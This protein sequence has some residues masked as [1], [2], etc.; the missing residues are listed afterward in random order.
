M[1]EISK[2]WV[3]ALSLET[4]SESMPTRDNFSPRLFVIFVQKK[5]RYQ[6]REMQATDANFTTQP[7]QNHSITK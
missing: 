7:E 6:L 4:S 1:K 3:G 2:E 5:I